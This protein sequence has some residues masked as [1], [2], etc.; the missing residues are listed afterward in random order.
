MERDRHWLHASAVGE[1]TEPL[2]ASFIDVVFR[3][4]VRC[5]RFADRRIFDRHR[6]R[7]VGRRGRGFIGRSPVARIGR[8]IFCCVLPFASFFHIVARDRFLCSHVHDDCTID[9]AQRFARFRLRRG[10]AAIGFN[11]GSFIALSNAESST[12]IFA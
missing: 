3:H 5:S 11:A 12:E 7:L 1:R 8:G 2:Q 10:P 4:R 6:R 9:T